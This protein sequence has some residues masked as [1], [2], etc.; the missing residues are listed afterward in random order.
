MEVFNPLY[1]LGYDFKSTI[2]IYPSLICL[3]IQPKK[4]IY[5]K[6]QK[7]PDLYYKGRY[8][9]FHKFSL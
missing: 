3:F 5:S 8:K 9:N 6:V 2:G 1:P 7:I 4:T